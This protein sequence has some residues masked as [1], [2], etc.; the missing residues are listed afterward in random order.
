[1]VWKAQ[2][3]KEVLTLEAIVQELRLRTPLDAVWQAWTESEQI[4]RWFSPQARIEAREGGAF[5]L[6][7][8]P[9]NHD[10]M[11]TK[12]CIIT[13]FEP[14][15]RLGFTWKGP[16]PFAG[17]MNDPIATRVLV[18]FQEEA[19][20]TVIRLEHVGWGE[21]EAW[22]RARQWHEEA[23]KQVLSSLKSTL[24]SGQGEVCCQ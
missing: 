7:F 3:A 22:A 17:L 1:V 2:D 19:G 13:Q 15:K 23:W 14:M 9:A 11:S 12:G 4:V 6:Y 5:E 24:E 20:E 10:H 16:D 8:D 18:T 21:G